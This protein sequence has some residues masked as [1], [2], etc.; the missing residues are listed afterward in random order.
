MLTMIVAQV[1]MFHYSHLLT[2]VPPFTNIKLR[3]AFTPLYIL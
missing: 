3:T 1:K 2:N